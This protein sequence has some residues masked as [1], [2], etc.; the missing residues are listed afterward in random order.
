M[1]YSV[2][3]QDL[4]VAVHQT[5]LLCIVMSSTGNRGELDHKGRTKSEFTKIN[6]QT[7]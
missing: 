7:F 1:V 4:R 5:V 6:L 3:L 2:F